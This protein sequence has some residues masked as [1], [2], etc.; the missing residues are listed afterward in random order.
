MTTASAPIPTAAP[1]SVPRE[2]T[3]S[4]EQF[5]KKYLQREDRYKYEWVN[6]L[7]EKTPRTMFQIQTLIWRNLKNCL[8]VLSVQMGIPLG[9]LMMKVDC[10]FG[11]IHRR[12]DISYFSE[13]QI[14]AIPSGN[15]VPQFVIE[16][17]SNTDQM[18]LV[19]KKMRDYRNANVPVVWHVFPDL[20]EVHVYQGEH[21]TICR[22][23]KLCS[24]APV[25]PEFKVAA[26]DIFKTI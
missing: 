4:W 9:E 10:F 15:Q 21:M 16:V 5:Q 19:H 23:E 3:I 1:K 20:Q 7:V 6:G 17:I 11:G 26:R 24:A 25:L 8:Q 22:G 18:L 2:K 13:A 12:P 14:D